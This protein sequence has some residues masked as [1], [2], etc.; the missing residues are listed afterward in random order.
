MPVQPIRLVVFDIDDTLYIEE[1]F[2]RSGFDAVGQFAARE[3]G[4]NGLAAACLKLHWSGV[5]GSVFNDALKACGHADDEATVRQLID[6]YR[7]HRPAIRLLPDALQVLDALKG[8][9]RMAAVSD[10]PYVGQ[11]QKAAALRLDGWIEAV[12]L[13][14]HWG[15][16]FWKPHPRAFE[17]L[18]EQFQV[19]GPECVYLGDSPVKDFVAPRS[20]GWR[21]IRIRRPGGLH[22]GVEATADKAAEEEWTNLEPLLKWL[23]RCE[24]ESTEWHGHPGRAEP[25]AA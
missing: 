16:E 14:D 7:G 10:G 17:T 13:T 24:Q 6:V 2:V 8:R 18:Q 3:L 12:I 15:R 5:R 25:E 23:D 4:I 9:Y 22:A 21:T 1:D 11:A 19:S 20:L